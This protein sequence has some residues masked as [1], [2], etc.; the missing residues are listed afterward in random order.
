MSKEL[1][2][3]VDL[4]PARFDQAYPLIQVSGADLALDQWLEYAKGL[5][6]RRHVGDGI[7]SVLSEDDY[8][9]ALATH[10]LLARWAEARVLEVELFCY[11]DLLNRSV[12][13]ILISALEDRGRVHGCSEVRVRTS[14]GPGGLASSRRQLPDAV[15]RDLGYAAGPEHLIKE[16]G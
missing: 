7:L 11:L 8:I 9:H 14:Q 5:H 16:L 15:F 10:K 3:V 6:D 2:S 1:Y 12:G 13:P 4:P